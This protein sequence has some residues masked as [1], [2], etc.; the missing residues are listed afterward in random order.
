ME[1][2]FQVFRI[3]TLKLESADHILLGSN[4]KSTGFLFLCANKGHPR[5]YGGLDLEVPVPGPWDLLGID[6]PVGALSL[7][8]LWGQVN[9]AGQNDQLREDRMRLASTT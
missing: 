9:D 7:C 1:N 3:C 8:E 5:G 4:E 6:S 2:Q